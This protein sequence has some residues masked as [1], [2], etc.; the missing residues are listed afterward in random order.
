VVDDERAALAGGFASKS[1]TN[2]TYSAFALW[3]MPSRQS[4]QSRNLGL[5]SPVL[6]NS[7]PTRRAGRVLRSLLYLVDSEAFFGGN[8]CRGQ[9]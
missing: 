4:I 9:F 1:C 5:A 2:P 7:Q 6:K 3:A 8:R